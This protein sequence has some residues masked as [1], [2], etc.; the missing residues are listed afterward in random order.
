MCFGITIFY[1]FT[2]NLSTYKF[3]YLVIW[4]R[5]KLIL[6]M[7]VIKFE[8]FLWL[9]NNAL[10]RY[11]IFL[12]MK[13]ESGLLTP[14]PEGGSPPPGGYMARDYSL[15]LAHW[16]YP[17]G[18]PGPRTGSRGPHSTRPKRQFICKFCQREFTKSYNLLIHERTHTDERPYSCDICGKAFRRQD[19]LRDHRYIK[20]IKFKSKL[21]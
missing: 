19:H 17:G 15:L 16:L 9:Y 11:L 4:K 5:R 8:F 21:D 20:L 13:M 3:G 12:G 6:Y 14:P 7:T 1:I 18:P 2:V 10:F